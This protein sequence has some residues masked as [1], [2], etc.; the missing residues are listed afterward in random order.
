MQLSTY[1]VCWCD[2]MTSSVCQVHKTSNAFFKKGRK[3][4]NSFIPVFH[5]VIYVSQPLLN[6]L[7]DVFKKKP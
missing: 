7:L 6:K 3:L 2:F 1:I 4:Y 5:E